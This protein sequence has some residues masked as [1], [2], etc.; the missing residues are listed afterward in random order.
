MA[1]VILVVEKVTLIV[2]DLLTGSRW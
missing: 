1:A 2:C